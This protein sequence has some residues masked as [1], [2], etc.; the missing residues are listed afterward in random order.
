[1]DWAQFDGDG[2]PAAATL[3]AESTAGE[4]PL[5]PPTPW[6]ELNKARFICWLCA[7]GPEDDVPLRFRP[8]DAVPHRHR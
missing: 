5:Y 7:S 6:E 8:W 3:S 2:P 1:M 4:P